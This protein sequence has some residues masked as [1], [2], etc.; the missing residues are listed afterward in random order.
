MIEQ[1]VGR[2]VKSTP[3]LDLY[4]N[5]HSDQRQEV[6]YETMI[7]EQ[8]TKASELQVHPHSSMTSAS[9][10]RTQVLNPV[11]AQNQHLEPEI[12]IAIATESPADPHSVESTAVP[13]HP[14]SSSPS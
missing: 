4:K 1:R 11:S 14:R 10:E 6:V 3:R 13:F 12:A 7:T 8:L 5:E 2:V 9:K